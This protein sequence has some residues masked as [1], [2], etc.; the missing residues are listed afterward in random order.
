MNSSAVPSF[1]FTNGLLRFKGRIYIGTKGLLRQ[2][3]LKLLHD[4]PQGGHSG[5]QATYYRMRLYFYWP[6][7]LKQV[8]EF[9][10]QCDVC[11]RNKAEHFPYPGLLQPIPI[12]KQ[13]W[14]LITMDFIEGLPLSN[15]ANCILVI[16]DKFT[17]YAHFL[18]FSHPYT[19]VDIAKVYLNQVYKLH[20]A[21][22]SIISD[23]DKVFTGLVCLEL[24]KLLGTTVQLSTAYH[25]ET[26]GQSK[27]L[28]Q[29]VEQYLRC[30]CFLKPKS[31]VNWLSLGEWWY[32]TSYHTAIGMTPFQAMYGYSPP[33]FSWDASSKAHVATVQALLKDR[34]QLS[35]L[36]IDQ[37]Q[38]AQQRMKH[39]ADRDRVDRQFQVGDE[40]Y[41]KLQPYRHTSLALRKNLKLSS[42]YYGPYPVI[43][44]IGAVAYKLKL[45]DT[46]KLH[47]V[48]HV[49]LLKKK[50]GAQT[51]ASI[52][53][54]ETDVDGHPLVYPAAVLDKRIV[55]RNN[56][57]VTQ[58]LVVWSNLGIENA[59][60]EDYTVLH[61]Q[62]PSFDPWGQGST[63]GWG[64][65][66]ILHN[67]QDNQSIK[68]LKAE[69]S[70]PA[71]TKD[72]EAGPKNN[73]Q[74]TKGAVNNVVI[75]LQQPNDVDIPPSEFVAI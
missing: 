73:S 51:V 20:G 63:K 39:Y 10:Q 59:T 55:K 8:Q 2:H 3:L 4:S 68:K 48:F 5:I 72:L 42:K 31:W 65:V 45:P 17:K 74:S 24:M 30:M 35:R 26:D 22:K 14:E 23:R 75:Q 70:V 9:I 56:Q 52:A 21:S 34:E 66:M 11:Q 33:G 16:I 7:M 28:N 36:M 43:S 41:L 50:I 54:P 6:S 19:A 13:A 18:P 60:W 49:S 53:P 64:N 32:N 58:L 29:C 67:D 71:G 44:R 69:A 38:K 37:L 61:S 46:S 12:P 15:K 62:F 27:R 57:A 47:P 1:S 25:S 40:V